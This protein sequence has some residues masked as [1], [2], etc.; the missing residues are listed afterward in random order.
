MPIACCDDYDWEDNDTSYDFKN[1]FGTCLEE[2]DNCYTI[3]A[4]HTINDESDYAYDTKRPKLGEDMFDEDDI[5]ENIFA[6]I[7]ACPKLGDATLNDDIFS[8]P[9]LDMQSDYDEN[10]VATYDDY[11]DDT[12]SIKVV[13][14]FI[15][16]DMIMITP[17][18]N[19]TLLIW[20]QFII[21][22]FPMILPL[23]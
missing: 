9:C 2:Y 5:F 22:E 16:L 21:F 4:I 20:K 23:F 18:L 11:C 17:S 19:I 7:N 12:Y 10:K 8:L 14:I 1:L 3:G 15:K 6:T 13:I